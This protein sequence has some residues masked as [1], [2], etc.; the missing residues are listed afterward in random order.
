VILTRLSL[1]LFL[2]PYS[3]HSMKTLANWERR[4]VPGGN[5]GADSKGLPPAAIGAIVGS[6][7]GALTLWIL[8]V[9]WLKKRKKSRGFKELED[10]V[11]KDPSTKSN[12][13]TPFVPPPPAVHN[14]VY[15]PDYKRRVIPEVQRPVSPVTSIADTGT[16]SELHAAFMT[17]T[18]SE[19][20]YSIASSSD[21]FRV[22]SGSQKDPRG[23]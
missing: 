21:P 22:V 4:A 9:I 3:S 8:L 7:L 1:S 5:N 16:H 13:I 17:E 15:R 14:P 11:P 20:L 18:I 6:L 23:P 19:D 2:F 10:P 12:G